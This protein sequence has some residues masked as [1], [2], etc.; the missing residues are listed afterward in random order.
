MGRKKKRN[1]KEL[2][3][4][5]EEV[6]IPG[7]AELLE[8]GKVYGWKV[9]KKL[10]LP[11]NYSRKI[12]V[13]ES[14]RWLTADVVMIAED[15][16]NTTPL[17]SCYDSRLRR[18]FPRVAV[19]YSAPIKLYLRDVHSLEEPKEYKI[20]D[21]SEMGFSF[22]ADASEKFG[23]GDDLEVLMEILYPASKRIERIQ[24]KARIVRD[25]EIKDQI[26]KYGCMFTSIGGRERQSLAR[27]VAERQVEIA[28]TI[29]DFVL[30]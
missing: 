23:I 21:V 19:S 16:I 26:K 2:L 30:D 17:A 4:F 7:K 9:E 14:D 15:Y 8:K 3:V 27:Y 18:K 25:E 29:K 11:I 10:I 13:K 1:E 24:G 6:P 12:F 20:L 5:Y 22:V 28:R